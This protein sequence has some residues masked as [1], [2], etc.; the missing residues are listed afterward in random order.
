M[1]LNVVEILDE[2]KSL[3]TPNA[4]VIALAKMAWDDPDGFCIMD[5][6]KCYT[7]SYRCECLDRGACHRSDF[8]LACLQTRWTN[9]LGEKAVRIYNEAQT[10]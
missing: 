7:E 5:S 2:V 9:Q 6:D 4:G 10:K 8:M 1:M 3:K